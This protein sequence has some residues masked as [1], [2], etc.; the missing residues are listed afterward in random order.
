MTPQISHLVATVCARHKIRLD[1]NDPAIVTVEIARLALEESVGL[2]LERASPLTDRICTAGL[3]LGKEMANLAARRILTETD[4]ARQG[5]AEEAQAARK[6]AAIAIKEVAQSHR[7]EHAAKWI[8]TGI[9]LA[10]LLGA[11]CFAA[12][13][14]CAPIADS[15]GIHRH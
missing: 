13:Y 10:S 7:M 6:A 4:L 12:G 2:L 1:E 5:I 14:A 9:A 15:Y 3:D 8:C 11:L